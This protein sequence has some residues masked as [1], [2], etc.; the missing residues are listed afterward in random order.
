[1]D[2]LIL[3]CG[4]GGGH[5]AAGAAVTDEFMRR[6]HNAIMLN[7]YTLH[8]EELARRI[9]HAYISTAQKAPKIFSAAYNAGQVYRQLPF[10]SP[11]YF[12]N[13]SMTSIMEEYLSRNHFDIILMPHLFP[14]EIITAMKHKGID[15]P[16]TIFIATDYACIP[17]TEE[18]ECDAYVIPSAGL[19]EEYTDRGIPRGKLHPLGIPVHRRFLRK[20]TRG[21]ARARLGLAADKKYILIAGGSMGGGRI[22]KVIQLLMEEAAG[23][24][25]IELIVICGSNR[26]L[27]SD[28]TEKPLSNMTVLSF[29]ADM[30]GYMRAADLFVTKPGG[31]S[32]TEAAASRIPV[33]HVAEIPGCETFNAR[34]FSSHGMSQLCSTSRSGLQAVFETL[35]NPRACEAMIQNQQKMIPGDAAARIC[36]LA[37]NMAVQHENEN[38]AVA[39]IVRP[40]ATP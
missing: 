12:A 30:D 9:D 17:F 18:T 38:I 37:E 14:A 25:D 8:S 39:E 6:G 4:T 3:S 15:I 35:D 28:L 21:E 10:R 2:A 27:Y 26:R 13:R 34:Y 29:T 22:R 19:A 23:R 36:T 33:I 31:L 7:P 20:E 40:V 16:K 1:M 5:N 32:S 24:S 11:V